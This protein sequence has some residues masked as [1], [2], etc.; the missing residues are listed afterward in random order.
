MEKS[1]TYVRGSFHLRL[2][3]SKEMFL[4]HAAGMM[5]MRIDLAHVVKVTATTDQW[6]GSNLVID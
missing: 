4:I 5:D 6:I 3:K 1:G 2:D